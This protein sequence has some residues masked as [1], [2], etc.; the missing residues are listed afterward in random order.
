[1]SGYEGLVPGPTPARDVVDILAEAAHN[2]FLQRGLPADGTERELWRNV[3]RAVR[4]ADKPFQNPTPDAY[5]SALRAGEFHRERAK[6]LVELADKLLDYIMRS[7]GPRMQAT[8]TWARR[9]AEL[10]NDRVPSSGVVGE[11]STV[12]PPSSITCPTCS[13]TSYHPEDV[14]Q[15]YCC[16]CH[17]YHDQMDTS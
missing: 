10:R 14:R 12:M 6:Q 2:A 9:L 17:R 5:S 7:A 16:F 11:S 3:A 1:M 13:R 4:V 15:R 8:S